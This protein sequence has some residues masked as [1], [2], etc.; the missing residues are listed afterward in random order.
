MFSQMYAD[1]HYAWFSNTYVFV[2]CGLLGVGI[3][4]FTFLYLF[5]KKKYKKEYG[6]L[7]EIMALL[8][9]F[10]F[11]YGEAL[12]TDAGYFVYFALACGFIVSRDE[13]DELRRIE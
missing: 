5:F 6:L 8:A 1:N 3:Y 11:F 9:I 10:L 2:Q 4:I 7:V 12:K 13:T